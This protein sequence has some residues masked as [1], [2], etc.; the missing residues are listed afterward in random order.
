MYAFLILAFR[1]RYR[2]KVPL[3]MDSRLSYVDMVG[4]DELDEEFDGFPTTRSQDVVRIRY[5]RLRALAGGAQTLLGDFASNGERLEALWNW[6]DLRATGIFVVFCLVASLV[7]YV[8]PFKM[9][10]LGSGFYYLRHPRFRDDMPSIPV[11]FFRRL[12][13]FLDQIL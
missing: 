9:F 13:S 5:D 4:L 2:Q 3:N 6:R 1:F 7:F 12:P 10:V 11:S 8:V